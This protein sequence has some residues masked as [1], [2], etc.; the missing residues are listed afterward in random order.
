M[1]IIEKIGVD[2]ML[3]NYSSKKIR[4][5]V[6]RDHRGSDIWGPI[7]GIVVILIFAAIAVNILTS[8]DSPIT[9]E[10]TLQLTITHSG[11]PTTAYVFFDYDLV[12]S[13][14]LK[15]GTS[16]YNLGVEKP[17][18][19]DKTVSVKIEPFQTTSFMGGGILGSGSV[20]LHSGTNYLSISTKW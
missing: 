2:K 1:H 17:R 5:N 6:A 19:S 4:F 10:C 18:Y 8:E 15:A 13:V 12:G 11:S 3:F 14:N 7:L 16:T 20:T 9:E